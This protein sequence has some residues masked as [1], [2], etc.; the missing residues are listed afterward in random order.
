MNNELVCLNTR[1][2]SYRLILLHGWGA[3]AEDLLSIG[4]TL[5]HQLTKKI[6]VVS[7]RAP[8]LHPNGIGRQ[9][10]PLFP[11]D[12]SAVPAQVEKLKNRINEISSSKIPLAKTVILGFSQG[13]AMALDAGCDLPIAGLICC[14]AYPHP[15][16][17]P[18]ENLSP[19]FLT[20]GEN[21]EI[22]PPTAFDKI[23][24][25]LINKKNIVDTELFNGG[26][27]IPQY[28]I[29]KFKLFLEKCF[30]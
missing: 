17:A 26:H 28:L 18:S 11:A 15:N 19:I 30:N 14:S 25:L 22:V 24:Q 27:E 1:D 9:W 6:E 12:W 3:D 4:E 5:N 8:E 29:P 20:H 10:Y 16:W 2:A 13:G 23:Q 21:D 7:M